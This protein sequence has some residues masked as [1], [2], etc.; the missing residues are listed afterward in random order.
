M[1]FT[2]LPLDVLS[3]YRPEVEEPADFD[4]FWRAT[5]E[6][7][8]GAEGEVVR[9]PVSTPITELIVEDLEFP[10]F[11]GEPIR[12]WI[13]RPRS[14]NPLPTVIEY[15]GYN[16]GRGV[17]GERLNW[18]VSGYAHILM[19]TRGQGSGWGTGGD[20]RDPY[21]SGP[22]VEGF[23]TKGIET[24]ETY[25]YRRLYTDAVRLVDAVR[26]FDFVDPDRIA[27]TGASQGGGIAL[28]V[29]GLVPHLLRAA[30]PDVPFLSHF[31]RAVE[32][33]P[34]RPFT[35]ITRYLATHRDV[36]QS[37]FSTLSYFDGANFARRATVPALF[38]VA[39]MDGIVIPSTVYAAFNRYAHED[40]G[41]TVYPYNGHEGGQ[42]HQ[43]VRQA[44]WLPARL[45]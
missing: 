1:P 4:E 26:K 34:E 40:R 36:E 15:I 43:W 11:A 28:A 8:R 39:L 6:E 14:E 44:E 17:V 23:M 30:M 45:S 20:T 29:A 32:A 41:I 16:G 7:A 25:Y 9:R 37:V 18:A 42:L 24:P 31:R 27:V 38:S 21:G 35:E 22:S 3:S 12:G 5:I 2:D 19:D 33:T 10:G 13:L